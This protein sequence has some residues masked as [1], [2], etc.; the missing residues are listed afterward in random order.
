MFF[1][2]FHFGLIENLR[3][4]YQSSYFF[5][6]NFKMF[7]QATFLSE[8]LMTQ[9]TL[10]R[11]FISVNSNMVGQTEFVSES[12]FAIFTL[13]RLYTGVNFEMGFQMATLRKA[14][15]A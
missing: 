4:G 8:F 3:I 7:V 9:F 11:F 2:C 5:S 13:E 6:V 1:F 10:K 15:V 12:L 14:F